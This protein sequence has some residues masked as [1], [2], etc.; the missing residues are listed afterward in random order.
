MLVFQEEIWESLVKAIKCRYLGRVK[1]LKNR[2][3]KEEQNEN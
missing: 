2:K 1:E 3:T